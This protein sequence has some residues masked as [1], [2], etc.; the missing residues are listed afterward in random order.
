MAPDTLP[1]VSAMPPQ[2]G[3][4]IT[5][6]LLLGY[7]ALICFVLSAIFVTQMPE[8]CEYFRPAIGNTTSSASNPSVPPYTVPNFSPT[9]YQV[10]GESYCQ[11]LSIVNGSTRESTSLLSHK[12]SSNTLPRLHYPKHLL[13]HISSSILLSY[14]FAI[15]LATQIDTLS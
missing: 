4:L 8:P 9:M 2:R 6:Q 7:L 11:L 12:H 5:C 14:T 15:H 1:M 3:N 13:Y 10:P